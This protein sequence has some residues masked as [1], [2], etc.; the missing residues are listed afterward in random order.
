MPLAEFKPR[1]NL[2]TSPPL[3]EKIILHNIKFYDFCNKI[4]IFLMSVLE[5][6]EMGK[7]P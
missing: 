1:S 7:E 2:K 3:S 4:E 6:S 5:F